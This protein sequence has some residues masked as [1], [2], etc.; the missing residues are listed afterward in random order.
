MRVQPSQQTKFA[1][2]RKTSLSLDIQFDT[3][4]TYAQLTVRLEALVAAYPALLSLESIGKSHEGRDVWLITATNFATGPAAEKPAFWADGNIHATEVSASSAC[5]Y[6]LVKLAGG[7]GIDADITRALDTRAFYIVP[8]VNPDGAELFFAEKP[9]YL[10]SSTRPYPYDEEPIEGLDPEDL[11]GNGRI[12]QMRIPDPNGPWKVHPRNP[13][14]L[15]RRDPTEIGGAY[16]RLLPEGLI[17]NWDALTLKMR[18]NKE[19]LDL[20]RNFPAHWRQEHEQYGAGPFPG[21][22]PEVYNLIQFITAHP[23][24]TG[25]ITFHTFGGL[26]LRPYGTQADDT[27]PTEDLWTFQTIGKKGTELTGYPNISVFHDFRYH[28][29]EVITGVFDDWMYDHLGVYAW[30]VELWSPQRQ[31][32]IKDYKPIDWYREHPYEDDEKM[33]AWSDNVLD[34]KGY[35]DWRPFEHPQLG[36]VEIGGWDALHAFRNPPPAFLEKEIAP[37]AEWLV[38]QAL[39]SPRLEI[40]SAVTEPLGNDTYLVRLVVDNTGWLPSYISKRAVEKKLVRDVV[41]EIGLP[42]GVTLR[43]GKQR[44]EVG[45]LEG[46]AYKSRMPY[47]WNADVTV[48]RVKVEW[49]VSGPPGSVLTL[50]AR[51]ERAGTVRVEVTLG[52]K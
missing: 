37:L 44:S 23:N 50:T 48:E 32:G 7:H 26:L 18:R 24:I 33:L 38:W 9:R 52:D 12:L 5:L 4:Y 27:M 43:T 3:Y 40:F 25:G 6:A 39:I 22:E 2:D 19:G 29:K 11:D 41:V 31:A 47:G 20:N 45:Q 49:T 30:T 35:V 42:E 16:F 21:S 1:I 34:G 15:C 36:S 28:P 46:R 10:R 17:T 13:R 51:H 14:L 8:R